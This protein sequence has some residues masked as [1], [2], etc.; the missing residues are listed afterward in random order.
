MLIIVNIII[1]QN[2]KSNKKI[3]RQSVQ[4]WYL[5]RVLFLVA[6]IFIISSLFF[7]L[8]GFSNAIY[9]TLFV[10]LILVNFSLTGYCPMSILLN[11][12]GIKEK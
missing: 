6:G 5:E 10:G 2:N 12:I 8:M 11:K 9:F 4:G 3:Y 1:M 7:V